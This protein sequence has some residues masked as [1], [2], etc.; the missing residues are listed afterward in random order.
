MKLSV[1]CLELF[2][3]YAKDAGN[4]RGAP[5]VGG[6]VKSGP[7]D[8]GYL[9]KLKKAGY[10][11]TDRDEYGTWLYFTKAGVDLAAEFSIVIC[12]D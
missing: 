12:Q 6:N 2:K 10:I 11:T 9:T 1:K 5:M 7:S 3:A 8:R 4:W